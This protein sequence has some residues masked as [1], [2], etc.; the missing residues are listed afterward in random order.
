M[1]DVAKLAVVCD[2]NDEKSQLF[3]TH[4]HKINDVFFVCRLRVLA[5][6]CCL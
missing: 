2:K 4:S 3:K 6:A 5:L 1:D